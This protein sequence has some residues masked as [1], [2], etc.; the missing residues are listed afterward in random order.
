MYTRTHIYVYVYV[1]MAEIILQ[2]VRSNDYCK[3]YCLLSSADLQ[4]LVSK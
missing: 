1:Y 4:R 3:L 2:Y